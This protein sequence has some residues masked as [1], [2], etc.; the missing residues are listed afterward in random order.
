[1]HFPSE[2]RDGPARY[3]F[4]GGKFVPDVAAARPGPPAGAAELR[5]GFDRR[6]ADFPL[7]H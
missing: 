7:T 1:M 6:R 4:L 5:H 3:D 2:P